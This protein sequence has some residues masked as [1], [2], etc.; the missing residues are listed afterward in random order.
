MDREELLRLARRASQMI[1]ESIERISRQRE[2]VERLRSGENSDLM[3]R[4]QEVLDE[5]IEEQARNEDA[6]TRV[7]SKL[8]FSDPR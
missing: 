3:V 7:Q 4:A 1:A 8:I 2:I 5:L 6:L